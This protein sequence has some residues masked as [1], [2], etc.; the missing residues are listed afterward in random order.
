LVGP[1]RMSVL[2][3]LFGKKPRVSEVLYVKIDGHQYPIFTSLDKF[4]DAVP[5]A[6]RGALQLQSRQYQEVILE[7]HKRLIATFGQSSQRSS[8]YLWCGAAL[9]K[10]QTGVSRFLQAGIAGRLR[11]RPPCQCQSKNR[12]ALAMKSRWYSEMA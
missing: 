10:L 1:F 3:R 4:L 6:N 11:A 9:Q 12:V 7:L 5:T 2:S 8:G